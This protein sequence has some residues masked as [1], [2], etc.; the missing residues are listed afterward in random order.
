M[1]SWIVCY[2]FLEER[3]QAAYLTQ[4]NLGQLFGLF[5]LLCIF[6]SLMGLFGLSGFSAQQKTKEIG[7]R[8]VHG[9][10]MANI[11][12]LLYKDYGKLMLLNIVDKYLE[13]S[14]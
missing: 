11:L 3:H 14:Q 2:E 8:V 13:K 9:A 1:D 6:L 7:I 4:E 5:A 10:S 12:A